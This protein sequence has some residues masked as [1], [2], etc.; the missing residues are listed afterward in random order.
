M[1]QY[2]G[3]LAGALVA[4]ILCSHPYAN[5]QTDSIFVLDSVEISAQSLRHQSISGHQQKWNARQLQAFSG[6]GLDQVL[7]QQTGVFVKS[8]GGGSL[9][10]TSIRGGSAGQTAVV[11]N[12]LPIQSPMLGQL[13]LSL[14][15]IDFV[16]E[17]EVQYGG[18]SA[19][20]GSGAIGGTILLNNQFRLERATK[21]QYQGSIGS[22]GQQSHQ[23]GAQ[24]ANQ[25]FGVRTR[26]LTQKA[27]NNFWY[28]IREDLP[29]IQQSNAAIDRKGIMQEVFWKPNAKQSFSAHFWGQDNFRE[30]PPTTVQNRSEATQ[31][32]QSLRL[33]LN[34]QRLGKG[35]ILKA[36]AGLFQEQ[37][38]YL[39]PPNLI[40]SNSQFRTLITEVE[41]LNYL[42]AGHQLTT[43]AHFQ[44]TE[45]ISQGY[46][47]PVQQQNL[48]VFIKDQFQIKQWLIQASVRQQFTDFSVLPTVWNAEFNRSLS[49]KLKLSGKVS[50]NYRLPTLNDQF[51]A[52][53]GNPDLKAEQG[54]SQELGLVY[55]HLNE[56]SVLDLSAFGYNR[57]IQ[58]WIMWSVAEG[59]NFWSAQNIAKVWSRGLESRFGYSIKRSQQVYKIS[60]GYDYTR[61]TNQVA[62][63]YPKIEAGSQLFYVPQHQAFAGFSWRYKELQLS[64][65]HRYTSSV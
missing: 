51:W 32:D 48:A 15:P 16:D 56:G 35:S 54:Y 10:T 43:G 29:L 40:E 23:L 20:W 59:D 6:G 64:Y 18:N 37:L 55:Q 34:W 27:E 12:G 4:L 17:L 61:S 60:G 36:R 19:M 2:N 41:Q 44:W 58:N 42:S 30:L 52:P 65:Q 62:L 5:A 14:L 47:D 22:F 38:N 31:A 53:G 50:R 7:A 9:A 33:S 26:V 49:P 25:K 28:S 24:W 46:P 63:E 1:K 3:I 21:L 8:Y 13:D 45:A 39:D 11:W 57:N